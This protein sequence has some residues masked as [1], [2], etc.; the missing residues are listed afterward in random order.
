M[1]LSNKPESLQRDLSLLPLILSTSCVCATGRHSA[2]AESECVSGRR[3]LEGMEE[4]GKKTR[5][6]YV[7][8]VQENGEMKA[9]LDENS[10]RTCGF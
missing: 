1:R 9:I 5:G 3:M 4:K 7:R 8:E 2:E 10:L 6:R